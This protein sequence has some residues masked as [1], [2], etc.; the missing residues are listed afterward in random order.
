[1]PYR[2]VD[3]IPKYLNKYSEKVRRQWM[4]VFN[5]VYEST[6]GNE[7]RAFKAANST[8]KKRFKGKKSME[9]NS[10]EDYFSYL[11]DSFLGNLRG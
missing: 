3:Q 6:N 1:M 8:L 11:T 9:S 10:R 5:S 7:G 2:T 4:H